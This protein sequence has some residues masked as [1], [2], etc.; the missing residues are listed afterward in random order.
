MHEINKN[1]SEVKN[2]L[3]FTLKNSLSINILL[4]SKLNFLITIFLFD[5]K[6]HAVKWENRKKK[7]QD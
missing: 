4:D 5:S 6:F 2:H 3:K 1:A 7:L